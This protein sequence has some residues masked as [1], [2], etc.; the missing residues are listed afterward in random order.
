MCERECTR[1]GK[2]LSG[3]K[4]VREGWDAAEIVVST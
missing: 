1:K 4:H 3:K 2:H